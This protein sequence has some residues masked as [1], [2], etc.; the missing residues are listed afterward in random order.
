MDYSIFFKPIPIQ[1]AVSS[2]KFLFITK[3]M[4]N[5]CCSLSG[6]V[7]LLGPY[8]VDP[9]KKSKKHKSLSSSGI[10]GV[11]HLPGSR[12]QFGVAHLTMPPPRT[13]KI[14][15]KIGAIRSLVTQRWWFFKLKNIRIDDSLR[16]C[17]GGSANQRHQLETKKC[18]YVSFILRAVFFSLSRRLYF[19]FRG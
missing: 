14:S 15:M 18:P 11:P 19:L 8:F 2:P 16:N 13:K 6:A 1:S 5:P 10:V 7:S 3:I 17:E 9:L 4:T 12:C